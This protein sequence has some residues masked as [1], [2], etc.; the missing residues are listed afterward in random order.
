V[1]RAADAT[2]RGSFSVPLRVLGHHR[3][4][5]HQGHLT[6]ED[7]GTQ[8]CRRAA[9]RIFECIWS[10]LYEF[11]H[12]LETNGTVNFLFRLTGWTMFEL[13]FPMTV[14]L[15]DTL[16][17]ITLDA[18]TK[19][20]CIVRLL[21]PDSSSTDVVFLNQRMKAEVIQPPA[22]IEE[23][24]SYHVVGVNEFRDRTH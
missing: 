20:P 3:G 2:R 4:Q 11:G 23:S 8:V 17:E 18:G 12:H 21:S 13:T 10:F 14:R 5:G 16:G 9:A 19:V 15:S 6:S 7:M 1:T 22:L 24:D